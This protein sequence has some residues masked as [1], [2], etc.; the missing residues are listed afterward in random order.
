VGGAL[1]SFACLIAFAILFAAMPGLYLF[2]ARTYMGIVGGYFGLVTLAVGEVMRLLLIAERD[3]TAG[4]FGVPLKPTG[5][6]A[7]LVAPHFPDKRV[8]YYA[9]LLKELYVWVRIDRNLMRFQV[10]G[11]CCAS[12]SRRPLRLPSTCVSS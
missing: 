6:D 8:F 1:F 2:L 12:P 11:H 9:I 4:S 3:W 5:S 7:S 10:A